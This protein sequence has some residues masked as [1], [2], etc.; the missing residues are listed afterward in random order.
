MGM[1]G[2]KTLK[3]FYVCYM[4]KFYVANQ[5][6]VLKDKA[7]KFF[8]SHPR[9]NV[10]AFFYYSMRPSLPYISNLL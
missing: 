9:C 5:I 7:D 10:V 6:A 2:P 1:E 8:V 4:D 3:T